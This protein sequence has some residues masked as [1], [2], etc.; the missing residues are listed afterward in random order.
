MPPSNGDDSSGSSRPNSA[1]NSHPYAFPFTPDKLDLVKYTPPKVNGTYNF[2]RK[3]KTSSQANIFRRK[4]RSPYDYKGNGSKKGQSRSSSK[5]SRQNS[6]LSTEVV[7]DDS[8]LYSSQSLPYLPQLQTFVLSELSQFEVGSQE[9]LDS[10]L[11]DENATK[12]LIV[13]NLLLSSDSF[14]REAHE[15]V[16]ETNDIVGS[17]TYFKLIKLAIKALLILVKRYDY[18]LSPQLELAVYFKLAKLYFY[19]TENIDRADVYINMA[20]AVAGRNNLLKMK[21]VSEFL[22]SRILEKTNPG[23]FLNYL[24]DRISSYND[25]SL[26]NLTDFLVLLK[27]NYLLVNDPNT[28]VVLLQALSVNKT[29]SPVIRTLCTL[30]QC[31]L[32]LHRGSPNEAKALLDKLVPSM[33]DLTLGQPSQIKAMFLLCRFAYF[34]QTNDHDGGKKALRDIANYIN[35]ERTTEWST[36]KPDGTFIL[37]V[38][39][40]E[41]LGSQS[42][43]FLITWLNSDEFVVVYYF[44]SGVHYIM[45]SS[46]SKRAKKVFDACLTT[47]DNQMMELTKATESRRNFAIDHLTNKI[48]R[49]SYIR[50]SVAYYQAW[51]SFMNNDFTG[52]AHLESFIKA[53]NS[54]EFTTEELCYYKLLIPRILY[55]LGVYSHFR[56]EKSTAKNYFLKVRNWTVL[57]TMKKSREA[58]PLQLNMGIGCESFSP[59]N[60]FSELFTFST[61]HLVLLTEFELRR[62]STEAESNFAIS[63]EVERCH[64]FLTALYHDLTKIFAYEDKVT[65][66]SFTM[67]FAN[68][69]KLLI[70]CYRAILAAYTLHPVSGT[71]N[72]ENVTLASSLSQQLVQML[73]DSWI[74][75]GASFVKALVLYVIYLGSLQLEERNAYFDKCVQ[76]MSHATDNDNIMALFVLRHMLQRSQQNG[77]HDSSEYLEIQIKAITDTVSSKFVVEKHSSAERIHSN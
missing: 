63:S 55:L 38:P 2:G 35:G 19:E 3:P 13:D 37:T 26:T 71:V 11:Q 30:Y 14:V 56:G 52:I 73:E 43:S 32:L 47:I 74:P 36:W 46:T 6:L 51:Y 44:L 10:L 40:D 9:F 12:E 64:L 53:L 29:L 60:E 21:F 24:N 25:M 75:K 41:T 68:S 31:S 59:E 23:L 76:Q 49:L 4:E 58:S 34:I 66:N 48:V 7:F 70:V 8:E 69:N 28:G 65:S 5:G 18:C 20:I 27:I 54:D 72:Q 57:N 62:L 77:E 33:E 17:K 42:T 22:A 1:G 39:L 67:N 16:L 61:F 15:L 50:Y 45:D